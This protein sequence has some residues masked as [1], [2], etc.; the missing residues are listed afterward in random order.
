MS[1]PILDVVAS[2][3]GHLTD[4]VEKLEAQVAALT[5]GQIWVHASFVG[6]G[7]VLTLL[8]PKISQVLGL[9]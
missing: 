6:G 3:V 7:V 4:R 1:G 9:S 5:R 2:D 8:L